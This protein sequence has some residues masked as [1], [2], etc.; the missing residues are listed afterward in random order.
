MKRKN[1]PL[2]RKLGALVFMYIRK[3]FVLS[4]ID[5]TQCGFK[6]FERNLVKKVFPKLEFFKKNK[7]AKGWTVTSWDVELLHIIEKMGKKIMEVKVIWEDTDISSSKGGS[8]G[9]YFKESKD[10]LF[11]IIRVKLNDLRGMY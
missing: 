3:A 7:K 8:F 2:Y 5:D 6:L 10:M 1:F 11:Q 9:R 4:D